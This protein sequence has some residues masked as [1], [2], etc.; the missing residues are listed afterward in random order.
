M[1]VE[2]VNSEFYCNEQQA[3]KGYIKSRITNLTATLIFILQNNL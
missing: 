3:H 2:L 1:A